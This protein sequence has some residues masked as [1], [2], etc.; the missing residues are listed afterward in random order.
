MNITMFRHMGLDCLRKVDGHEG[1]SLQLWFLFWLFIE[2]RFHYVVLAGLDSLCRPGWP[3][4]HR[5]LYCRSSA[6]IT[7][8]RHCTLPSIN[9][10]SLPQPL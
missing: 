5:D 1:I 4:T 3:P 8:E 7:V 9:S 10:L 2:T 6:E